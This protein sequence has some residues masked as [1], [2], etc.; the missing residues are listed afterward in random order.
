MEGVFACC[1][2]CGLRGLAHSVMGA[3]QTKDDGTPTS[4]KSTSIAPVD[5]ASRGDET[6]VPALL[7]EKF[8]ALEAKLAATSKELSET[9]QKLDKMMV[10][11]E[12]VA[13]KV[14]A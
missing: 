5:H 3:K 1:F 4:P 2:F 6:P 14:K 8:A 11:L 12:R 9:Q 10:L 13:A 7:D